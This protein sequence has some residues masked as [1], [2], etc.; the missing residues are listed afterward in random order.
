M[1]PIAA[2]LFATFGLILVIVVAVY[3]LVPLVKG[4]GWLVK[5][6]FA[7]IGGMIGSLLRVVGGVITSLVFIPL[8]LLNVII[9]RWSAAGHFGKGLQDELRAIGANVYRF[10]I[11]HPARFLMLT[12]LV[13]GLERRVP[14]AVAHAPT[15]DKPRKRAGQFEGYEIVGSLKGGGS[16]GRLYIAKPDEKKRAQFARRGFDAETVVIK[17]FSLADGSSLPQIVRESRALD[18]AKKLGLVLEHELTDRRFHYVMRYVPGDTLSVVT[19][20]L[21]DRA[22]PQGLRTVELRDALTYACDLTAALDQYH[23]GGLW[24]K[25]VKPDNIIVHDGRAHLVD[26]GL[27]TPLRSAM[28]LTTH[29][30]EYFR[31]PEM[32]RLALKGVKVHE[33]NG[34]KFD[35][36]GAGAVLYSVLENSFPAHGVLSQVSKK[37]PDSLKWIVRRA[38]ADYQNR[39]DTPG[40]M[41]ADL[42]YVREAADP[43]AVRVADL[44]SMRGGAAPDLAEEAVIA[45]DF[46]APPAASAHQPAQAT[47]AS[48]TPAAEA[49]AGSP[50]PPA[51]GAPGKT[52]R[53]NIVVTNWWRGGFRVDNG[54]AKPAKTPFERAA[55][56]AESFVHSKQRAKGGFAAPTGR[57]AAEQLARARARAKAAQQRAHARRK[58]HD[59]WKV[60][61]AQINTGVGVAVLIFLGGV[62]LL[63]GAIV[64]KISS[65]KSRVR[66]TVS[67]SADSAVQ[68]QIAGGADTIDLGDGQTVTIDNET[69]RAIGKAFS[70][71]KFD[72]EGDLS[73]IGEQVRDIVRQVSTAAAEAAREEA[74]AE[75]F[76]EHESRTIEHRDIRVDAPAPLPPGSRLVS[77]GENPDA[78]DAPEAPAT[79]VN[80]ALV[81][82]GPWIVLDDAPLKGD[83]RDAADRV[84]TNLEAAGVPLITAKSA[85]EESDLEA[86]ASAR[87]AA[88][89]TTA[90]DAEASKRLLRWLSE[91]PGDTMGV[92]RLSRGDREDQVLTVVVS[93]VD[94]LAQAMR[95]AIQ[96]AARDDLAGLTLPPEALRSRRR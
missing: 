49:R 20:R 16:G 58:G 30:T 29:G 17:T 47:P 5:H 90:D 12:P 79:P 60:Y 94:D 67:S 23:R 24:H 4:I 36:F 42:E 6:V 89:A 81:F 73:K 95:S 84:L 62:L 8:I 87:A 35:I 80:P 2:I 37:C 83:A 74:R 33:V 28:T 57:S 41:L 22:G 77:T 21:H 69:A 3:V 85:L 52:S 14:Q 88:G 93:T 50:V 71:M 40:Q 96:A 51:E 78:P 59:D 44:P 43:F 55:R 68:V 63:G 19:Q 9:G 11:G 45:D 75:A 82:A 70:N 92:L 15:R 39:Y 72:V 10:F 46:G 61:G 26:F 48:Y 54:G 56:K 1:G 53:P 64:A 32:V 76:R 18:A 38:M 31:D 27:V 25:D 91:R 65:E 66:T 34:A 86:L 13:D 7:F